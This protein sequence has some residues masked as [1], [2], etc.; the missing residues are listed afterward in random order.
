MRRSR[1]SQFVFVS[2]N[3]VGRASCAPLNQYD[4]SGNDKDNG[5]YRQE[6]FFALRRP[7]VGYIKDVANAHLVAI[8]A[9]D[10]PFYFKDTSGSDVKE[11]T[12]RSGVDDLLKRLAQLGE[13]DVVWSTE[14]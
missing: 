1:I 8:G 14:A 6:D 4:Y 12:I 9:K 11:K 7:Y 13:D 2:N 5:G 3:V 10:I